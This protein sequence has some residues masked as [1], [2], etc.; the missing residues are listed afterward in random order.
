MTDK[1]KL[2]EI[3]ET[4][5]GFHDYYKVVVTE[6]D[7]DRIADKLIE[8]GYGNVAEIKVELRSK[9]DYIHE[10]WEVKED[11]KNR[12]EV[13]ERAVREFSVQVGCRSCPFRGRCGVSYPDAR[14][15][16]QDCYE[17]ILRVSAREIKEKKQ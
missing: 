2:K 9:V 4:A 15:D 7:I 11:Y 3:I 1:E 17:A 6:N 13:A 8:N 12:A 10:L 16:Y 5:L 14:N